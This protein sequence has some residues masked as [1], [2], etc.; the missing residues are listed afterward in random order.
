[1]GKGIVEKIIAE[2]LVEGKMEAGCEVGLKIDHTLT[3]D[4]TGTMAYLEFEAM[5]LDRVRNELAVSYIDHNT[6]QV[7]PENA[8]DHAFLR[9]AAAKYGAIFSRPGNGICHQIHLERFG[10]PGKTLLGSD[11]HT[12]T[13]GGAGML[14]IGAGGIDVAAAMGGRPFYVTM[15]Q[16]AQIELKGSLR[17]WV[18]AKDIILKTLEIF[19]T[20]GNVGTV[21]EY[22]GDA[23]AKLDVPERA[24]IANMGAECGVTSSVFPSDERTKA[25]LEAQGRGHMWRE[26]KADEDATYERKVEIDLSG[27]EPLAATPHS[28]GN[29][30]TVASL[31]GT[32]VDQVLIGSCTNASYRDLKTVAKIL[33]GRRIHPSVSFGV[34]PGSR[35]VLKMITKEGLLTTL[36]DS[37]ARI[38]ESA[39]GFCIGNS[40][41]PGTGAVSVRTSNRNFE[42]RSGTPSAGIYLVSPE[43]AAL[44]AL[45]GRFTEAASVDGLEYPSVSMPEIFD[46]DDSMFEYP[47]DDGSVIELEK[48]GSIGDVPLAGEPAD[49]IRGV[50]SIKVGDKITTDHIMPAGSRLK[51]RSNIEKYAS[52]VFEGVDPGFVLRAKENMDNGSANFIIAGESYGQGSSREHAAMCPMRLG[53]KAVLAKSIERIH[54]TNLINFGILPSV[55]KDARDYDNVESGDDLEF[56]GVIDCLKS[57]GGLILRNLSRG[58]DIAVSIDLSSRERAIMLAGGLLNYVRMA[59]AN[60]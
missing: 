31:S 22:V 38:L 3:Q 53:V 30:A 18:S 23:V 50:A 28:P 60:R 2:H 32:R 1:M 44:T 15:P 11:S 14:A 33:E 57:G 47:P 43:T 10:A 41:S 55:F 7:G 36:M 6:V 48:S 58:V 12:A 9:S 4:A 49:T 19:G 13:G 35:Q 37:G 40:V 24:T 26:L 52:F 54:R 51:Y 5:G 29:I 42:G 34:A 16:V 39:C 20:K 45:Y 8:D 17:P 21:F 59:E 56:E 25:F 27:L 46:V